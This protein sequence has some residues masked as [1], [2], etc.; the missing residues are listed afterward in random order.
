M[1]E[2]VDEKKEEIKIE[3][4]LKHNDEEIHVQVNTVD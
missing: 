1:L 4:I 2:K 3:S